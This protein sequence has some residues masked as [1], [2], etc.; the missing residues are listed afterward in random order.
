MVEETGNSMVPTL[1]S[2]IHLKIYY[3][4]IHWGSELGSFKKT[5]FVVTCQVVVF[6]VAFF[7][8]V[9]RLGFF[10]G[11]ELSSLQADMARW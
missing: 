6:F 10:R 3:I 7:L 9:T 11:E 1:T 2:F 8:R 5:P 4:R